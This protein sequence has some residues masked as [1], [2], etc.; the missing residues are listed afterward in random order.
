M[1]SSLFLVQFLSFLLWSATSKK[2]G[3]DKSYIFFQRIF[4]THKN[5]YAI[6]CTLF[7][8]STILFIVES[9]VVNGIFTSIISFM[10]AGSLVVLLRPF[11]Y[12]TFKRISI[13]FILCLSIELLYKY[14][15]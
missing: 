7:L 2:I 15:G 10:L 6:S 11:D 8:L 9:N 12:L 14:A 3:T 13:S 4:K 5:F 1:Y